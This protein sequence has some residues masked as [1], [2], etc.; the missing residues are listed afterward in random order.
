MSFTIQGALVTILV[1]GVLIAIHEAGHFLAAKA[2]R[3]PVR[4]FAIGFGPRIFGFTWGETEC[5]LNWIPLGGYCAFADDERDENGEVLN[6]PDEL[7]LRNR[8]IWQR[9]MVVSAGVVFNFVLAWFCFLGFTCG[10]GVPVVPKTVD[11]QALQPDM[12]ATKA[13]LQVGDRI[14]R[15]AGQD[16]VDFPGFQKQIRDYK[17]K[18]VDLTVLR[19][20]K[21][22][23]LQ[24][25]PNAQGL[26]GF[27][28]KVENKRPDSIGEAIASANEQQV[29]WTILL[30]NAIIQLFS[31]PKTMGEKTGG[32]IAIV[33]MGDQIYQHDPWRL[34]EFGGILSI[35][36]FVIN[37]LPVP[38]LDG[39][40]LVL[41]IL[42][43]LRR[44]P[45][46]RRLEE[47]ILTAGFVMIMGLGM[48]LIVKDIMTV[49]GMYKHPAAATAPAK[50]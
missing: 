28:V 29:R 13:G 15:V 43:G 41:L 22:L 35:E 17:S 25:T 38:A 23:D 39:G 46:S 27:Q 14:T 16:V 11:V 50:P 10:D 47:R 9:I 33:A 4:Q 1:L 44:R 2:I 31:D 6:V 18:Q 30:P 19:A 36:L 7:L 45:L 48:V 26:L 21:T 37:L 12:P 49:P 24:A 34:L 8:P 5:R 40:H 32:P 42:E 3:V 20:G